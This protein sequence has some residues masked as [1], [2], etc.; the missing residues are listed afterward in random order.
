MLY[1]L[2]C[3]RITE[4][5]MENSQNLFHF[6]TCYFLTVYLT[7]QHLQAN[8]KA[9]ASHNRTDI[10]QAAWLAACSMVPSFCVI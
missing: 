10:I 7:D 9:Q 4:N 3:F 2:L 5:V 1:I 8:S 6:S